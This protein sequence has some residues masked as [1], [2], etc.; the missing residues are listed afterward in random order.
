[1]PSRFRF[2]GRKIFSQNHKQFSKQLE[3]EDEDLKQEKL[4]INNLFKLSYVTFLYKGKE[5]G[6]C[7]PTCQALCV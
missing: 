7:P 3:V 1:L 5:I 2:S 6:I 4:I